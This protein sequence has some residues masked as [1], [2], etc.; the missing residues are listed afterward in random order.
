MNNLNNEIGAIEE[1][2][3][4]IV[5][6][7]LASKQYNYKCLDCLKQVIFRKG[8]SKKRTRL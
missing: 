7:S 3:N 6:P 4:L 1:E 8:K 2:T 5:P